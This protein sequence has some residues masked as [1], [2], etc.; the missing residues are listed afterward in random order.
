MFCDQTVNALFDMGW[1][2]IKITVRLV[3]LVNEAS[4]LAL[5]GASAGEGWLILC[6]L[7]IFA[8]LLP[9]VGIL[10]VA[11]LAIVKRISRIVRRADE[12]LVEVFATRRLLALLLP[13]RH[14]VRGVILARVQ[15]VSSGYTRHAG[16]AL[17][18][19]RI[20]I[21]GDRVA[22]HARWRLRHVSERRIDRPQSIVRRLV[23]ERSLDVRYA[24][25]LRLKHR[26][27]VDQL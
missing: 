12:I 2:V 25:E 18:E 7:L 9:P 10:C 19:M 17:Q 22:A 14:H 24:A 16:L 21:D 27:A 1:S 20:R 5:P 8:I 13:R 15:V 26:V 23:V 6:R 11:L 4:V 3:D